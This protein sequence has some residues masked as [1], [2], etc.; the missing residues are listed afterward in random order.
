MRALPAPLKRVL[1]G[2]RPNRQIS[3]PV[4]LLFAGV[5]AAAFLLV[6]NQGARVIPKP[7]AV[8]SALAELWNEKG[9]FEHLSTSFMLNLKAIFWSTAIT[10]GLAYLTVLPAARPLVAGLS[11]L[12]FLGFVGLTFVFTLY[13]D[14]GRE[15]KL[16]LL[17]FGMTVF[18]LTSM[19]SVVAE[20]P[21]ERFDHARTLKM[22]EW[23]VVWEVVVRG[24]LDKALETLRQNAAMG[25]MMLTMVEGLVRSEGGIG[26]MMLNEN[27]HLQLDAVFALNLVVLAVGLVQD[28]CL[29][30]LRRT[31]CPHADLKKERK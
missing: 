2:F 4:A 10:L 29:G 19:A 8:L 20:I 1:D 18:F 25:W 28:W 30:W 6:W 15:L 5:T 26:A 21:K 16:W 22:G 11:K 31:L 24:T 3:R 13:A 23:R 17:T 14:G 12:R 27:K 7:G 9:L